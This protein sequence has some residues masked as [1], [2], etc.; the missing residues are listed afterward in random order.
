MSLEGESFTLEVTGSVQRLDAWLAAQRPELS[1]ARVQDLIKS[2]Q[3]LL[4]GRSCK[5]SHGARPGDRLEVR[6]PAVRASNALPEDIPLE[7]LYEDGD[8]LAVN[9]P[10]GLVTHP[11]PGH[12]TGTLVNALLH[13]C[14]DLGGIGGER[15]PGI[16][17]RLDK[18][19][20][21][22][23][24]VAKNEAALKNLVEQFKN[25]QVHKEYLALVWG[26]LTPAA[27]TIET[28]L[29]R[30]THDRKKMSA[31]PVRGRVAVTHYETLET[32]PGL[33]LLRIRIETGR[34]HQIRVHMAHLGHPVVGDRQYGRPRNIPLPAPVERQLLHAQSLSL[35][36][37]RTGGPLN[38]QAPL[39][40]DFQTLLDALRRGQAKSGLDLPAR[41]HNTSGSI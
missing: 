26:L 22:V 38:C 9:K 41:T 34:T 3:I 32:W 33:S 24:V 2:G 8:L 17:H 27:G 10:A 7:V 15:R 14:R 21:G 29:G 36:H 39:P 25:R 4:N 16:V 40:P 30:S 35:A 13:H 31:R 5:P 18:D 19:T 20:T 6:L 37:P 1:R 28:L 23:L 11:A 12:D